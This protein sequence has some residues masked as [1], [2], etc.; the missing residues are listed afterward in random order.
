MI[1]DWCNANQ[2]DQCRQ[3]IQKFTI[4]PKKNTVIWLDEFIHC[5]CKKRGCKCY[6][7][8]KDRTK[9]PKR[10]TKK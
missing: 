6:V 10:K 4:D 1:F 5:E 8:V 2:H 3:S 7:P 9:K